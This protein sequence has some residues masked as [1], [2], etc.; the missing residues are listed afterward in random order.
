M[1]W[2]FH[3][4]AINDHSHGPCVR[5]GDPVEGPAALSRTDSL[6]WALGHPDG[7]RAILAARTLGKL[8]APESIPA[9]R[10]V[11]EAGPDVFLRA[12]ALLSLIAITGPDVLRPWLERLSRVGPLRV[13]EIAQEALGGSHGER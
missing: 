5:C 12:E 9:L 11:V 4:Y 6:I 3:C 13:R 2:C 8:K 7:D 10:A 1:F